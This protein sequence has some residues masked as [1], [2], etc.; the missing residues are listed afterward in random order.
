MTSSQLDWL[1]QHA[2]ANSSCIEVRAHKH[3]SVRDPLNDGVIKL[4]RV[5]RAVVGG[6]IGAAP[7]WV[8]KYVG[9][10]LSLFRSLS[11]SLFLLK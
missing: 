11:L 5:G 6:G 8:Q 7:P 4:V 9:F 2:S 1:A 3:V 10:S